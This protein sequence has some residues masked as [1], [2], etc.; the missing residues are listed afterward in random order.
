MMPAVTTRSCHAA[1]SAPLPVP[2]LTQIRHR[3]AAR[4][5][6]LRVTVEDECTYWTVRVEEPG[7]TTALYK[8]HRGTL[9]A[10]KVAGI[11][12]AV[13]HR[14]GSAVVD[15]SFEQLA[16]VLSWNVEW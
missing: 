2:A 5:S 14:G 3:N 1:C 15:Q 12:F 16:L 6:D 10:A 11:E 8:A 4:W 7:A 9:R 13:F